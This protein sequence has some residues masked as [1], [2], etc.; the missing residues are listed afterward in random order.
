MVYPAANRG[1]GRRDGFGAGRTGRGAGR[2]GRINVWQRTG[3]GGQSDQEI[4]QGLEKRNARKTSNTT[5]RVA[6][7]QAQKKRIRSGIKL[8][9]E[10]NRKKS[11]MKNQGLDGHDMRRNPE[12]AMREMITES[13]L[14]VT[15]TLTRVMEETT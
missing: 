4:G 13:K 2:T 7:K 1:G 5:N 15:C 12:V 11:A 8:H 14:K 9:Q 3:R 6:L 10:I